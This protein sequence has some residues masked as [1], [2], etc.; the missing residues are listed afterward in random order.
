MEAVK[1]ER[2]PQADTFLGMIEKNF[3][4]KVRNYAKYPI[5]NQE[6][7]Q[8]YKKFEEIMDMVGAKDSR[9]EKLLDDLLETFKETIGPEI[10]KHQFV[11]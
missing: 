10:K 9:A 2:W 11:R 1:E 5:L 3:K 6:L 8:A 4:D 7:P